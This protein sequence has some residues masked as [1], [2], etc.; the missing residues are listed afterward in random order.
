V[1]KAVLLVVGCVLL[2][3]IAGGCGGGKHYRYSDEIIGK[4]TSACVN[5][6]EQTGLTAAQAAKGCQC[7]LERLERHVR[8]EVVSKVEGRMQRGEGMIPE[9]WQP[10]LEACEKR[11]RDT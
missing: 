9:S 1:A 4:F 6:A 11:A 3:A 8:P 5:R 10:D 7:I 2:A